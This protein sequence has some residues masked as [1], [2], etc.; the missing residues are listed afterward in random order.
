MCRRRDDRERRKAAPVFC[1][2][3]KT[4]TP[5]AHRSWAERANAADVG[6]LAHVPDEDGLLGY[7]DF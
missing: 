5:S 4:A 6:S 2:G 1:T 7:R 3:A